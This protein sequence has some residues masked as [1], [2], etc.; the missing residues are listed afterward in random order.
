MAF[1]FQTEHIFLECIKPAV[2]QMSAYT[3]EGG[4]YAGIKL[5][6]NENPFDL[7]EWL[8]REILR[9][10]FAGAME[11]LPEHLRRRSGGSICEFYWRA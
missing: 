2:R 8:K 10:L 6:Q 4:Q 1:S 3:V 11:P 7:P 9:A 5:N